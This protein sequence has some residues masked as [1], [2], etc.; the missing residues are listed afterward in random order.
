MFFIDFF[1]SVFAE[2][3]NIAWLSRREVVSFSLFVLFLT[4]VFA[5]F[6]AVVDYVAFLVVRFFY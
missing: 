5:L 2:F 1:R 6:F 4:S 3:R